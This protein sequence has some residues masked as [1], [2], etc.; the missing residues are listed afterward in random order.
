MRPL[1]VLDRMGLDKWEV[2]ADIVAAGVLPWDGV[3]RFEEDLVLTGASRPEVLRR[4]RV[5]WDRHLSEE[6][7]WRDLYTDGDRLDAAFE[8]L[9]AFG[10]D[11][12]MAYGCC[13]FCG[14]EELVTEREV[15]SPFG[16][17]Q[18]HLSDVYHLRSR[19]LDLSCRAV[20]SIAGGPDQDE[21]VAQAVL[22]ELSAVGLMADLVDAVGASVR[23]LGLDWKHRV[24]L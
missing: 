6:Q 2:V 23:V 16:V 21:E 19:R 4:L 10:I 15:E 3:L 14:P 20:D 12:K 13:E 7:T 8:A 11:T 5:M 22:H 24:P 1:A 9:N 17:V 18:F